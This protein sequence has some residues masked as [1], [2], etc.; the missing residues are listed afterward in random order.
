M[1]DTAYRLRERA[2]YKDFEIVSKEMAEEQLKKAIAIIE[3]L[4]P[5][6]EKRWKEA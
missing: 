3:M 5:Y 2:D 1:L 4:K 6:L